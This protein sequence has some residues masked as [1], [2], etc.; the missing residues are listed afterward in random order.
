MVRKNARLWHHGNTNA[1]RLLREENLRYI[2]N[3]V[4]TSPQ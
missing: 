4:V 1:E 2:R 3:M